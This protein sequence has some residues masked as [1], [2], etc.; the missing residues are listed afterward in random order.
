MAAALVEA[1]ERTKMIVTIDGPAGAGKSTIAR[2]LA[3][4]LGFHF[5]DTGAMYRA[6]SWAAIHASI[7]LNDAAALVRVAEHMR[8][9]FQGDQIFVDGTNV[10]EAIRTPE[11]TAAVSYSAGNADV[12][13]I[14]VR[15]QRHIGQ[16][17]KNLVT[18]GRDQG[19]TVFP[20]AECKIYLT[21]TA[22]ER[23]KRRYKELL[24]KGVQVT[25]EEVLRSQNQRDEG[26][27][28]RDCGPLA[29]AEDAIEVYT[30]GMN[31]D[32]VLEQLEWLVLS[33]KQRK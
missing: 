15:A 22:E 12:R 21:A 3:R 8:L 29:K 1:P 9:Q 25:F 24:N 2:R 26:D 27:R 10:T 32:E 28:Q 11:V 23:A 4:R 19:T 14:M 31:Q 6:V 5:L 7:D 17:A 33:V 16:A 20:D 30:D 13:S 18:E